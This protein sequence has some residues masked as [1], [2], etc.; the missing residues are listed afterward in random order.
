MKNILGKLNYNNIFTKILAWIT[1]TISGPLISFFKK[2]KRNS[3]W[4]YK[5]YFF[6]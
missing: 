1:S 3:Y 2:W 6:F 5:F 4:N